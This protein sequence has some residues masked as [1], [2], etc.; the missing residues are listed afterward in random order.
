VELI[1][2]CAVG[3]LAMLFYHDVPYLIVS[4]LITAG[5]IGISSFDIT[6][7]LIPYKIS[8]TLI[9]ITVLYMVF[10]PD[11]IV[12]KLI[13]AV[14]IGGF[15]YMLSKL[16]I[17]GQQA[18]GEGDAEIGLIMGGLLGWQIG[19]LS[20]FISYI[21]GSIVSLG[22]L[23]MNKSYSMQTRIPFGPFL[24]LGIYIGLIAGNDIMTMYLT[25]L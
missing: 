13:G 4:V 6:Y 3:I 7:Q 8:W 24:A 11:M 2:A 15:L 17:R 25:L 12:S 14:I 18:G 20:L 23:S 9:G 22:I 21:V 10:T 5:L 1:T 16:K 19:L